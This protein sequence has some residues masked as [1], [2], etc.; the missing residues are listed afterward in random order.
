M[1]VTL[2]AWP[3]IEVAGLRS[4]AVIAV[5]VTKLG[6]EYVGLRTLVGVA[7]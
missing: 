1:A 3:R 2:L 4:A 6:E 5:L 7:D